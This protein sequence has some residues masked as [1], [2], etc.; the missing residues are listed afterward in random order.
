MNKDKQ[1]DI[2]CSLPSSTTALIEVSL[3]T[4][5]LRARHPLKQRTQL[6]RSAKLIF[7]LK[8]KDNNNKNRFLNKNIKCDLF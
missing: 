1:P 2:Q 6:L 7:V 8:R 4:R 5:G 3:R